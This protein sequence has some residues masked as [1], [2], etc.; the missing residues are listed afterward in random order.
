M[1]T[2]FPLHQA[3]FVGLEITE[4]NARFDISM[5]RMDGC[6]TV[7]ALTPDETLRIASRMIYAVWCSYP[8]EADAVV[9]EMATDIPIHHNRMEQE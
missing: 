8:D 5:D 9:A 7:D 4:S 3:D 6:V 1:S 2:T